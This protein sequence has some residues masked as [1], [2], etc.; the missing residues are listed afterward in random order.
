MNTNKD[1]KQS[2]EIVSPLL[3]EARARDPSLDFLEGQLNSLPDWLRCGVVVILV[4]PLL[5]LKMI[6]E[7]VSS[8]WRGIALS[9]TALLLLKIL[10]SKI[11]K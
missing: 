5:L 10:L 1:K 8:A 9:G 11:S 3:G 6:I 7:A 2:L 4:M